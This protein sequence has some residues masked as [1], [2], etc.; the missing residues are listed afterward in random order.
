MSTRT[1]AVR[2]AIQVVEDAPPAIHAA[3]NR[4][5]AQMLN[6]NSIEVDDIVSILFTVTT[7]LASANPATGLRQKGFASTPLMCAQEPE[8]R[9]AMPRV[10]RALITYEGSRDRPAVPI[11]LDGAEALRPDLARRGGA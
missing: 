4:L 7:D 5:V 3:A 11:Y 10:V 8:V 6:A 9:G 1:R 2:G